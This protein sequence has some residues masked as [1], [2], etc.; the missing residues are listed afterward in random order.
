MGAPFSYQLIRSKRRRR[1]ISLHVKEDGRIVVYTPYRT[2][3]WEIERFLKEKERWISK[4]LSEK[5]RAITPIER[6][7]LPGE[8]FLYLGEPY[9]LELDHNSP[10]GPSLTLSFGRFILSQSHLDKA[11][12]LFIRWYKKEAK[13]KLSDRVNYYSSRFQ[14][15]PKGVKI[16]SARSRWGSCSRDNQLCFSWRLV[17]APLTVIDYVLLHELVHIKEKNHSK[18]FWSYLESILPD[19][20]GRR[21]WLR[22]HESV[23]RL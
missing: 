22:D 1:T 4:K 16:T 21:R 17:M 2:P 9:P 13:D 20:K 11:R 18:R 7:F 3:E 6:R 5:E 14:L 10:Q 12:D 23:L 15:V 8:E 19:Y